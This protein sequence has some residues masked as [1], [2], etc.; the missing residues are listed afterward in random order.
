MLIL[1]NI[2]IFTALTLAMGVAHPGVDNAA[3][4]GGLAAGVVI[5]GLV[6]M[7]RPAAMEEIP[8]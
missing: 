6:T 5:G 4:I 7:F 1:V 3:H 8:T 2:G